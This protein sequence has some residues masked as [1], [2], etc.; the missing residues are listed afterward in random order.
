MLLF[1][2]KQLNM[3]DVLYSLVDV[4]QQFDQLVMNLIYTRT[5]DMTCLDMELFPNRVFNR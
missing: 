3:V 5:L 4:T 1:T 2:M